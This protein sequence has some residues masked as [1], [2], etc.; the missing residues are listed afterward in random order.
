[1]HIQYTHTNA[2]WC[3]CEMIFKLYL[4]LTQIYL[5]LFIIDFL[6]Y[7][8]IYLILNIFYHITRQIWIKKRLG[9][10]HHH[11]FDE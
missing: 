7:K 1:M 6:Y 9:K 3:N 4:N 11:V 8:F 10:L 2:W 5:C